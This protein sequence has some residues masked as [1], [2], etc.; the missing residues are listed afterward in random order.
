MFSRSNLAASFACG[1]ALAGPGMA[2]AGPGL[3]LAGPGMAAPATPA[4][5]AA[6]SPTPARVIVVRAAEL[7]VGDGHVHA[8][9]QVLLE[10]GRI[11]ALGQHV[12]VP[13]GAEIWDEP[14]G[15]ITPW[16]VDPSVPVRLCMGE[17]G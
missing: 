17:G 4:K 12:D 5:T 9:G 2:L 11:K 8:P 3:A 16:L 10:N 14:T 1:L 6:T 15:I 7:H 13:E